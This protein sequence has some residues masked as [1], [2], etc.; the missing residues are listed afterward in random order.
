MT[1]IIELEIRLGRLE[2]GPERLFINKRQYA[3]ILM[4]GGGREVAVK[5]QIVGDGFD[6]VLRP[7]DDHDA[8]IH[9]TMPLHPQEV[10]LTPKK[11]YNSTREHW[12]C[13]YRVSPEKIHTSRPR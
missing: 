13:R 5:V 8:D 9:W 10:W 12:Q 11:L 4:R 2:L 7:H 6:I 1:Y 3:N